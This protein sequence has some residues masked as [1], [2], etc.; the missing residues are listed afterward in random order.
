MYPQPIQKA[1]RLT[2]ISYR[3]ALP[4]SI[5]MWLLPLIAVMMTSIR[6]I[7]DINKGNYWGIPS[8]IQFFE[9]Y[10]QVFTSTP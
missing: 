3:V 2:N 4:I 7:E 5:L 10:S 1:G 6:S 9:N 8:D